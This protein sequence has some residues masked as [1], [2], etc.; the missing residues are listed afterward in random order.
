MIELQE[1]LTLR[2]AF[3]LMC[4]EQIGRG[5]YRTVYECK[6]NPRYVIKCE[7]VWD[8]EHRK[9]HNA[10]EWKFYQ[11]YCHFKD[12]VR[13]LAPVQLISRDA[14]ILIMERAEPAPMSRLPEK[15]PDFLTDTKPENYGMIN[16]KIVCIDY[17]I[18]VKNVETR[19]RKAKWND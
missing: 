8:N 6:L 19:L 13:W 5:Q 16:N 1:Y 17:A 11:D 18:T 14:R 4:G 3:D 12:I 7:S 9:F 15:L 10:A 2:D